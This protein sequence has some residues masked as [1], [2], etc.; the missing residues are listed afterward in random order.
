MYP[1]V[2]EYTTK[3]QSQRPSHLGPPLVF[4]TS[5]ESCRKSV[6]FL[7]LCLS[8]LLPPPSLYLS[9][10]QFN[11]WT[12]HTSF[13]PLSNPQNI[14]IKHTLYIYRYDCQFLSMWRCCF[15]FYCTP[16]CLTNGLLLLLPLHRQWDYAFY[17]QLLLPP[18]LLIAPFLDTLGHSCLPLLF[19]TH[20]HSPYLNL[21][22]HHHQNNNAAH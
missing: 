17:Y 2:A 14:F 7:Q 15:A 3:Q 8:Q 12:T 13:H 22:L 4:F 18:P 6:W 9:I 1:T 11:S 19:T 5:K 20:T 16:D 21:F 10:H